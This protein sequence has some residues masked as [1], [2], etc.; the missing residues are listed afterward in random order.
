MSLV[1]SGPEF[2]LG[3]KIALR[4]DPSKRGVVTN[5]AKRTVGFD[6]EVMIDGVD[7]WV[8]G[9]NLIAA[10]VTDLPNWKSTQGELLRH[11]VVAKLLNPLT[12]ALY[13]YRSSRTQHE[14]YQ[15]RPA[16]KFLR[17]HS[18]GILI[19]DEVGLGK[20]IEAAIIYLELK[21]RIDIRRVMV[22]CLTRPLY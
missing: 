14:P 9:T 7:Q 1:S 13:S 6:Y 3:D 22:L 18:D 2:R 20:T 4:S 8:T 5:V 19:A 10:S 15:F 11:L 17:G 12:D 21:A 16:L